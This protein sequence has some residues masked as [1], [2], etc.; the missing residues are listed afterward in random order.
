MGTR[1]C[2][3]A[4]AQTR[5]PLALERFVTAL[6]LVHCHPRTELGLISGPAT[7]LPVACAHVV[8]RRGVANLPTIIQ[9]AP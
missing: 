4:K 5:E 6:D 8:R 2:D 7:L 3:I 9:R 1:R